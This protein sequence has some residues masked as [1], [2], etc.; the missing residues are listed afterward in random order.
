[1]KT[2]TSLV[3]LISNPTF[4]SRAGVKAQRRRSRRPQR[5]VKGPP[6]QGRGAVGV[7]TG[8]AGARPHDAATSCSA[9]RRPARPT[10][11][12]ARQS[13]QTHD[14]GKYLRLYGKNIEID[15]PRFS[16]RGASTKYPCAEN[17]ALF[18]LHGIEV[19]RKISMKHP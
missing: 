4:P 1:M 11:S 8:A 10:T 13:E 3:T 7:V 2:V 6:A 12:A 16:K 19:C 17:I 5:Q 15:S 14:H 9:A 18:T